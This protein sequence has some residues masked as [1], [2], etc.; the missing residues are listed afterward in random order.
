MS[1][2]IMAIRTVISGG[3]GGGTP[4]PLTATVSP[5]V[6]D[7]FNYSPGV[8]QTLSAATVTITGGVPPYSIAWTYVS[9]AVGIDA[10]NSTS[11]STQFSEYMTTS[12]IHSAVW[13]AVVTDSATAP[14]VVDSNTVAITLECITYPPGGDVP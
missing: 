5:T 9:G 3:G 13:K 10:D 8:V 12:S 6:L 7:G 2:A 14:V 4:S 1:G 11:V